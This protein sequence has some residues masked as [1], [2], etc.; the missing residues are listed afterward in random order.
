MRQQRD[1]AFWDRASAK[2][3]YEKIRIPGYHIGGWYDGYRN[4]LPRML[5][6]VQAPVKAMIGPWDHY[7]PHNAWPKPQIE[8][9]MRLFVGLTNG[10]KAKILAFSKNLPSPY[11]FATI[12]HPILIWIKCTATGDGKMVGQ[13][14]GLK[15]TAGM[16]MRTTA[17][18]PNQRE[19]QRTV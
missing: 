14:N 9:D 19:M 8:C 18:L 3:Q 2:G 16:P 5:E 13:L 6:N 12:I 17:C 10:L 1:G 15:I 7:F 4:S 11:M